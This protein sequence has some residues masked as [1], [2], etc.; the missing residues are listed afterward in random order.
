MAAALASGD[1]RRCEEAPQGFGACK[2]GYVYNDLNDDPAKRDCFDPQ[3]CYLMWCDGSGVRSKKRLERE[4]CVD[5]KRDAPCSPPP[6]SPPASPTPE[7]SPSPGTPNPGPTP[8]QCPPLVRWGGG[9]H[10]Q[11]TP[12]FQG[13]PKTPVFAGNTIDFDSTARFGSGRGQPCNDE[14][15]EVCS[16]PDGAW[17]RCEDPRGPLWRV[18]RGCGGTAKVINDGW[19]YRI[20]RV[21]A[22]EC[23]VSITPREDVQDAE[24][25]PVRVVGDASTEAC[26]S[27]Q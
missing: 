23:C 15:H 27:V 20:Q 10:A 6:S 22:G 7:T 19:G 1:V 3:T 8:G 21:E 11:M 4:V 17:R 12:Q 18:T 5:C 24:G 25:Q 26:V 9:I 13:L 14:H 16:G 2:G